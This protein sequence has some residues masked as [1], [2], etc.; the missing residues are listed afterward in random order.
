MDEKKQLPGARE[1]SA[2][3]DFHLLWAGRKALSLLMPN[4]DLNALSIEGPNREEAIYLDPEGDQL[5]AIDLAEYYGGEKFESANIIIFAQLKYST[6]TPE[7]EWTAARLSEGKASGKRKT[8]TNKG[9]GSIIHRLSQ[10]FQRYYDNY[11]QGDVLLKL[12]LKLVSN[13]PA[14]ELLSCSLSAA[15]KCLVN[16]NPGTTRALLN[17]ISVDH[18]AEIERL[19]TSSSLG[20]KMFLDFL[21]VLDIAECGQQSRFGQSINLVKEL[22]SF[23]PGDVTAQYTRL[24][25]LIWDNMMPQNADKPPLTKY[26]ILPIFNCSYGDLFPAEPQLELSGKILERNES[27]KFAQIV[28]ASKKNLV[29]LHSGGGKG[30]TTLVQSLKS[31]LPLHYRHSG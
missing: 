8:K 18:S 9:T 10:T 31:N 22:G 2:G 7:K 30:K 17:S 29:C 26:D 6:R 27:A 19:F 11:G 28:Q 13:R 21:R 23:G 20:S 1:S 12:V 25:S 3:D 15:K 5:L 16:Q 24:K 14:S 4:S